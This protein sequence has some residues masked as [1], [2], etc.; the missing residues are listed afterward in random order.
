[1][2]H[3]IPL[4][5]EYEVDAEM[6]R[7]FEEVAQERR[8]AERPRAEAARETQSRPVTSI[9]EVKERLL[10]AKTRSICAPRALV[11][12]GPLTKPC[13][14]R[15]TPGTANA[16]VA[17]AVVRGI[18]ST[19]SPGG[20]V[21]AHATSPTND[22]AFPIAGTTGLGEV[23][24]G[25]GALKALSRR[26]VVHNDYRR[27]RSEYCRLSVLLNA[28]GR[29]A[30]AFRPVPVVKA[31]HGD[32]VF[33][34]IHRDQLVIDYHWCHAA[35]MDLA[36]ADAKHAALLDLGRE[37][38]FSEAWALA[39]EKRRGRY[40][41]AEAVILTTFQ[42]CQTTRLRGP[43]LV[44]RA[45]GLAEG[46]RESNGQLSSR[47]AVAL[48]KIREWGERQPRMKSERDVYESLWLARELLGTDNAK[49]IPQLVALMLG[50]PA[51]DRKTIKGK[52]VTLDKHISP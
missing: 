22:N 9:A 10:A 12:V 31:K 47:Q 34:V 14:P 37:F 2:E 25:V 8:D 17:S 51:L 16:G 33:M 29:M 40:R 38:N 39:C 6:R 28:I 24:D 1:M 44:G 41:A 27:E 13:T 35:K 52:L 7:Y 32:P 5:P 19:P 18:A 4:A 3:T 20:A 45:A 48:R 23:E 21:L 43:E 49:L 36:P 30:P 26:L 11:S 50:G 46:Y 15:A 42:Q